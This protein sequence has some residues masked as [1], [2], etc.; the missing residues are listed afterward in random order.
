MNDS[1]QRIHRV[2]TM[3]LGVGLILFG[4]LFLI[5]IFLP[6]I[7]FM[8]IYRLWPV[9]LIMLGIEV[10]F[11]CRKSNVIYDKCGITILVCLVSFALVMGWMDSAYVYYFK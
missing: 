8:V 2:G 4:G 5:K 1:G 11:S 6:T 9:I 3:T 10:L 7:D